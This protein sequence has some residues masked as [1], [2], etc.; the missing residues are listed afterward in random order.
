MSLLLAGLGS[1]LLLGNPPRRRRSRRRNCGRKNP[2]EPRYYEVRIPPTSTMSSYFT[3]AK[4]SN[5]E[6][7]RE[8]A[9]WHYNS[10]RDHDGL[11]PVRRLPQKT[12]FKPVW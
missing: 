3:N 9:L 12:K 8:N 4:G 5:R 10:A 1:L 7:V 2:S 11:P 6:T